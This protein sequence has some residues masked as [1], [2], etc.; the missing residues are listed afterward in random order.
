MGVLQLIN[1]NNWGSPCE[2][3]TVCPRTPDLN[4][5]MRRDHFTPGLKRH[6]TNRTQKLLIYSAYHLEV[7]VRCGK[8]LSHP[9]PFVCTIL[10]ATLPTIHSFWLFAQFAC[11][12]LH[13]WEHTAS[14]Q[15]GTESVEPG[16][17]VHPS[18]LWCAL[19]SW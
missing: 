5:G 17:A 13:H 6:K 18:I 3:Q 4:Q 16:L 8:V 10:I 12:H 9:Q 19:A 15:T 1:L 2:V 7:A 11:L 14:E